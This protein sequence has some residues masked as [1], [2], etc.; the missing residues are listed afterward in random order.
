MICYERKIYYDYWADEI[1]KAEELLRA[2][3]TPDFAEHL[4]HC[5]SI[6]DYINDF[7]QELINLNVLSFAN[8]KES[9]YRPML[10]N[11][12]FED[13]TIIEEAFDLQKIEDTEERDLKINKY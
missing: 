12:G 3:A 1:K 10:Q 4:K 5:K 13:E 2:H 8:L 9:N 7:F 6:Y 11:I